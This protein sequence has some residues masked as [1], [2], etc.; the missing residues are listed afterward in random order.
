MNTTDPSGW[1]R[2]VLA[3]TWA[4]SLVFVSV[5]STRADPPA[6]SG[7]S[8]L[9]FQARITD[10]QGHPLAG[11]HDLTFHIYDAPAGNGRLWSE[12]QQV[13][14][15]GGIVTATLG[16][17]VPL[18][19]AVFDPAGG[20]DRFVGVELDGSELARVK[21]TATAYS[22][23]ASVANTVW[24][25]ATATGL[26]LGALDARYVQTHGTGND[27]V[28]KINGL[29]PT[30]QGDFAITAGSSGRVVVTPTANG[31]ELDATGDLDQA[32]ADARYV[33][34]TGD[35]VAGN[36]AVSGTL[37]AANTQVTNQATAH[38]TRTSVL[39]LDIGNQGYMRSESDR[40]RFERMTAGSPRAEFLLGLPSNQAHF[41]F[42]GN[43]Y[44]SGQVHA[45]GGLIVPTGQLKAFYHDLG[46]GTGIYY[47]SLEGPESTNFVR[48]KAQL[49]G[50]VAVIDLPDH[51]TIVTED[52][53]VT[54]HVTPLGP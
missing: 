8:Q 39:E 22:V 49:A 37:S 21:L 26:D 25:P 4:T 44:V 28:R 30:N 27:V 32:T 2:T 53:D 46:N 18:H 17:D 34:V 12:T 48:G 54:A 40:F 45:N 38:I 29:A 42:V 9:T 47:C 20:A 24:D 31:V 6:A 41:Q 7:R 33:N 50:G 13:Q 16:R 43:M 3:L 10:P 19:A 5:L 11:T 36:L 23:V 15:V 1:R 35:T 51:F 14:L 52:D